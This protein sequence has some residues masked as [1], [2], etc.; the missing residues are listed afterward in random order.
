MTTNHS[1]SLKP[2]KG[3]VFVSDLDSG[4][5]LTQAGIIIPDDDMTERGIRE[6][7]A[8]VAAVGEDID[9]IKVGEWILIKHGRWTSKMEFADRD[10]WMVEYPDSVLL[11]SENDPRR[12]AYR[13]G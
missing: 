13:L 7:W 4:M 6:R 12:P 8:R 1:S 3:K 9:D 5:K 11:V 10:L 2:L